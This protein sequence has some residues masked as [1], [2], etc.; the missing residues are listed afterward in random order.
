MAD[1]R[2]RDPGVL[3]YENS[4]S[5]LIFALTKLHAEMGATILA[6]GAI[7]SNLAGPVYQ[8]PSGAMKDSGIFGSIGFTTADLI[9]W[10]IAIH[11]LCAAV[12]F[13]FWWLCVMYGS[14]ADASFGSSIMR[15]G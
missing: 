2:A 12:G 15:A 5:G 9:N 14:M 1:Q 3:V 11:M 13:A 6:L 8:V 10:L 7:T 4:P